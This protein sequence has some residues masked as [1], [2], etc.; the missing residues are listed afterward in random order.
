M[1]KDMWK[2]VWWNGK[3][4]QGYTRFISPGKQKE[5]EN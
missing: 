4:C 5:A 3:H 1:D 2:P